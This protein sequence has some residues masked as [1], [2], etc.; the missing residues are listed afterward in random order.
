ML[1]KDFY[2]NDLTEIKSNNNIQLIVENDPYKEIDEICAKLNRIK[3][4]M[5]KESSLAE[6]C[7]IVESSEERPIIG[8]QA[9]DTCFGILFYDRKNKKG[10]VGHGS[11]SSK[12]VTLHE[13]ISKVDDGTEKV[14]EYMIIP[15]FRNVDRRDT[16]GVEELLSELRIY[17]SS[18]I[19]FVPFHNDIDLSV[20]LH[21]PT[22][23]YEFAFDTRNGK[24]VSEY[25]FFDET[26]VN[27][28]YIPKAHHGL[29]K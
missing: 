19:K 21:K 25:V 13:M 26:E 17:C 23:T 7:C 9:L 14:I 28:R 11:P 12:V 18:N 1:D 22:L 4:A 29:G 24:F 27:P 6:M 3:Y 20:K 8:T 10:M 5:L 15:G 16:I 2:Y